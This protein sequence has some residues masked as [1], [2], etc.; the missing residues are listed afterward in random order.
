[1][2]RTSGPVGPLWIALAFGMAIAGPSGAATIHLVSG[3]PAGVAAE[4]LSLHLSPRAATAARPSVQIYR[5][6]LWQEVA[7]IGRAGRCL[8]A[9]GTTLA[10]LGAGSGLRAALG[11]CLVATAQNAAAAAAPASPVDPAVTRRRADRTRAAPVS[12]RR[13]HITLELLLPPAAGRRPDDAAAGLP[14]GPA[15][16]DGPG[17]PPPGPGMPAAAPVPIPGSGFGLLA[18][19]G[20]LLRLRRRSV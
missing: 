18:A 8:V 20:L 10:A 6:A 2:D 4:A 1:M 14:V 11:Q 13:I 19:L 12:G 5:G 17:G 16:T 15:V 9:G 7:G 3:G